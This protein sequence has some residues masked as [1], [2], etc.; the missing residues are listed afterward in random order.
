MTA[1]LKTD[2]RWE[3][4]SG[5]SFYMQA[6]PSE[7]RLPES[8][9]VTVFVDCHR[10]VLANADPCFR[11]VLEIYPYSSVFR[12][13]IDESYMMLGNHRMSQTTYPYLYRTVIRSGDNRDMLFTACIHRIRNQFLHLFTAADHRNLGIHNLHDYIAAMTASVKLCCHNICLFPQN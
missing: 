8:V 9:Q 7:F 6:G 11:F 4:F 12:F 13:H 3:K 5:W 1:S 2:P 10:L